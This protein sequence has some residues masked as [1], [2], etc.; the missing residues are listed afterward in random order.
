VRLALLCE[1]ETCGTRMALR[2]EEC[3]PLSLLVSLGVLQQCRPDQGCPHCSP[4][5][6]PFWQAADGANDPR[7]K[8]ILD[9]GRGDVNLDGTPRGGNVLQ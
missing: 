6:F 3:A 7:N 4:Q 5:N 9:M 8:I 2:A 1:C